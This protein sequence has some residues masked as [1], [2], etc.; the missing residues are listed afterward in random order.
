MKGVETKGP[1]HIFLYEPGLRTVKK[2]KSF[3]NVLE[4]CKMEETMRLER[5]WGRERSEEGK[6][7]KQYCYSQ[8]GSSSVVEIP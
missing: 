4:G 2:V 7:K 8:N 6:G 5:R 1:F 3:I